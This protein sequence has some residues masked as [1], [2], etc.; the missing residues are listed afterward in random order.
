MSSRI[1]ESGRREE[2][3]VVEAAVA[4][5]AGKTHGGTRRKRRASSRRPSYLQRLVRHF[6]LPPGTPPVPEYDDAPPLSVIKDGRPS[7]SIGSVAAMLDRINR[8]GLASVG[9]APARTKRASLRRRTV[10]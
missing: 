9:A 7:E 6:Q 5:P 8:E 2:R 4:A 10:G 3:E 1:R